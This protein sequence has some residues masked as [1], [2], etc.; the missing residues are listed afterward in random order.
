MTEKEEMMVGRIMD[1]VMEMQLSKYQTLFLTQLSIRRYK[2][3]R[4]KKSENMENSV[5][6]VMRRMPKLCKRTKGLEHKKNVVQTSAYKCLQK[7]EEELCDAE[8]D[9][10]LLRGYVVQNVVEHLI[11]E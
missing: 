8:V 7:L 9:E 1:E 4:D 6:K 2:M 10:K 11:R 5:E 3:K